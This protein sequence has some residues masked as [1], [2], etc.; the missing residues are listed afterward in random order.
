[1]HISDVVKPLGSTQRAAEDR[2][3][4]REVAGREA[5]D[6]FGGLGHPGHDPRPDLRPARRE[7]DH[8]D[9]SVVRACRPLDEPPRLQAV[10]DAGDVRGVAPEPLDDP[11]HGHP[12]TRLHEP[13]HVTLGLGELEFRGHLR[14]PGAL[15]HPE[16]EQQLPPLAG[17]GRS[18]HVGHRY[19]IR[20]MVDNLK[21]RSYLR[22]MS[23]LRLI[24]L[25]DTV[26]FPGM[27]VTLPVDVGEESQVLLVPRHGTEYANVG[28]VADV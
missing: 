16:V 27:T 5:R 9:T 7:P 20:P 15:P 8:P 21:G 1:A 25:E 24:A 10:D 14:Q 11:A 6:G 2:A 3:E 18:G 26:V 12:R 19:L 28:T 4:R 13:Q 23:T 22:P 17:P